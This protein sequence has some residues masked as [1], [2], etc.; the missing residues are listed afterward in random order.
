MC[1]GIP[2]EVLSAVEGPLRM[3]RVAFGRVIKE[4]CLAYVPEAHPGD[5]VVVHAGFA[6]S[7]VDPEG[8][9]RVFAY[10]E[11]LGEPAEERGEEP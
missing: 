9:R 10:L 11:E 4:V 8:A 1:L 7:R 2:G 3:G 5:F 6:I